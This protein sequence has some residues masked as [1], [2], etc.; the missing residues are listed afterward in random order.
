MNKV[1]VCKRCHKKFKLSNLLTQEDIDNIELMF[2][3]EGILCEKCY[4]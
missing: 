1:Y 4:D 3:N 2:K